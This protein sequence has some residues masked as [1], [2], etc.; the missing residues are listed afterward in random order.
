MASLQR[1]IVGINTLADP[2]EA[3]AVLR[4]WVVH[5]GVLL[6]GTCDAARV[7]VTHNLAREAWM[8]QLHAFEIFVRATY[9]GSNPDKALLEMQAE[10]LRAM[11]Q[12]DLA[13][14][15]DNEARRSLQQRIDELIAQ[16]PEVEG[17][18]LPP[19][20][21]MI[22]SGAGIRDSVYA[23]HYRRPS[24]LIHGSVLSLAET[25][26]ATE[27]GNLNA[28][29]DSRQA[30]LR[31]NEIVSQLTSY[32]IGYRTI[33]AIAFERSPPRGVSEGMERLQSVVARITHS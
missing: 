5:Y 24:I 3:V 27:Q 33:V 8:N 19:F 28:S 30:P 22:E 4:A 11:R 13:G 18:K 16:H 23:A 2:E 15:E 31:V 32:L 17:F 6:F 14:G 9:F 12:Y 26:K 21:Q 1:D 25:F 29:F 7:L 20:E 10:P